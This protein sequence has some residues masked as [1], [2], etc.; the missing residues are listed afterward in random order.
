LGSCESANRSG[1]VFDTMSEQNWSELLLKA[2]LDKDVPQVIECLARGAN[3][4]SKDECG[5]KPLTLLL[6]CHAMVVECGDFTNL[7]SVKELIPGI[8]ALIQA[9]AKIDG[10]SSDGKTPL[11]DAVQLYNVPCALKL[12]ELG[13]NVNAKNRKGRSVLTEAVCRNLEEVVEPLLSR[14]AEIFPKSKSGVGRSVIS[15]ISVNASISLVRTLV[16]YGADVKSD[17]SHCLYV[18][19]RFMAAKYKNF[20]VVDELIRLGA[21]VNGIENSRDHENRLMSLAKFGFQEEDREE[22]RTWIAL[23]ADL[24]ITNNAGQTALDLALERENALM[25]EILRSPE[26]IPRHDPTFGEM[27]SADPKA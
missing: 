20:A 3:P 21:D 24:S 1:V 22:A 8:E 26:L 25:A 6:C 14:G 17:N 7:K 9:G 12:I 19:V 13:A 4:N 16:K 11:F 2:C 10:R 27:R 5:D 15:C 23:G 18:A